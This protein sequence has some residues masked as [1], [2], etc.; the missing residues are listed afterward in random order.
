MHLMVQDEEAIISKQM[1]PQAQ[2]YKIFLKASII[3]VLETDL[4]CGK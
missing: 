3:L 4:N 2:H 1:D